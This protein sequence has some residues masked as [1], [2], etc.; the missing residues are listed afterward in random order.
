MAPKA[1]PKAKAAPKAKKEKTEEEKPRMERPD[2]QALDDAINKIQE[3]I[4]KLKQKQQALSEKLNERKGGNDVFNAKRAELMA[5]RNEFNDKI[6][7]LMKQ[8]ESI[9]GQINEKRAEGQ[10]MKQD[11]TKMKKSIGFTSEEEIDK[12]I[13]DIEF[14]LWT[15]SHTLKDEKKFLAEIQELK[16]NRPKVA[17]VK[18]ME[19]NVTGF[20]PRLDMKENIAAI[21][22]EVNALRDGRRKIQEALTELMEGRKSEM[23][24]M[25][26]VIQQKEEISKKIQEKIQ[27]RNTLRDDFRAKTEEYRKYMDEVRAERQKKAMEEKEARNKE[28]E[29]I[30]RQRAVEKLDEQPHIAEITLI[31][32]TMA[33]CKSLTASKGSEEKEEKKETVYDAPEGAEVMLKKEDRDEFWFAPTKAKGKK[34]KKSGG[35]KESGS[36][37]PIKHNAETFRLFDQLKLDAPITTDDIPAILEKL[38]A[39]LEDYNAKVKEWEEK[40]EDMK[41][42]ILEGIESEK[43]EEEAEKTEE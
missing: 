28:Y 26:P 11:L 16:R 42:A 35:G 4:D 2:R 32:Q 40:R 38:E 36:S 14:K 24:D 39:Q 18:A 22:A 5:Q 25:G 13:A 9:N 23:G 19:A 30:K 33:F 17:Q 20:D 7:A 27:E 37:K 41:K 12:R 31:E 8:K 1:D 15:D 21:N 43:K 3:D 34:G 29:I 6:D 10:A